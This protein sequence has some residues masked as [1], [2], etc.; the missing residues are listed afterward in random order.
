MCVWGREAMSA[1]ALAV[2]RVDADATAIANEQ[3]VGNISSNQ[4]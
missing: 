3:R 2:T 4:Q 1:A